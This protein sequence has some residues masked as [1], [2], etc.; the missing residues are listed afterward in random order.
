VPYRL[1]RLRFALAGLSLALAPACT[2]DDENRS[3]LPSPDG[4]SD[5]SRG[6][7]AIVDLDGT[8]CRPMAAGIDVPV[9]SGVACGVIP[10]VT[11]SASATEPDPL[12]AEVARVVDACGGLVNE[13][14]LSVAFADGCPS[15]VDATGFPGDDELARCVA[16][17]A[18][19]VR[20]A[21]ARNRACVFL[22]RSTLP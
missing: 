12:A 2:G 18:A 3:E 15:R 13:H 20:W 21:C 19:Y 6:D 17:R 7:A 8:A 22:T 1:P 14:A 11:C 9:S 10:E 5:A 16:K 4:G